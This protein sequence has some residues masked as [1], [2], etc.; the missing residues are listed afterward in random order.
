MSARR[1]LDVPAYDRHTPAARRP[2]R[3]L[4]RTK[5]RDRVDSGGGGQM[6]EPA[7]IPEIEIALRNERGDSTQFQ[8]AGDV[9]AEPIMIVKPCR[10]RRPEDHQA[11]AAARP[12][13]S[14]DLAKKMARPIFFSRAAARRQRENFFVAEAALVEPI[15]APDERVAP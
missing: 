11:F 7:V 14:L 9:R 3:R 12:P 8:I 2:F 15:P 6:G 10:F 4:R 5:K 1:A 13:P